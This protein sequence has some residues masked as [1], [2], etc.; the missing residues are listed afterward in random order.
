MSVPGTWY[1]AQRTDP[2]PHLLVASASGPTALLPPAAPVQK[3][4]TGHRVARR[5]V[6]GRTKCVGGC[7]LRMAGMSIGTCQCVA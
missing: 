1:R 5:G 2:L 7:G 6:A 4:S 3:L